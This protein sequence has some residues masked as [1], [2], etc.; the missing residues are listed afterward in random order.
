MRPQHPIP[1]GVTVPDLS[2][3]LFTDD[4]DDAV[5]VWL[6]C[7]AEPSQLWLER[8]HP[9][10]RLHVLAEYARHVH[11]GD[12]FFAEYREL[13]ADGTQAWVRH[14][15]VLDTDPSTGRTFSRGVAV[16]VG[17]HADGEQERPP[18]ELALRP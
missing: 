5:E 3:G 13:D 10:D 17:G 18:A 1:T 6:S 11:D 15:A 4:R 7:D 14:E 16:K 8:I 12:P 9:A 2:V